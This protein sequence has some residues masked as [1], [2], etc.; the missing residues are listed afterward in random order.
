MNDCTLKVDPGNAGARMRT[1]IDELLSASGMDRTVVILS[2][3]IYNDNVEGN[4]CR[5][6]A[7]A[8]NG[9]INRQY[10]ALVYSM[11]AQGKKVLLADMDPLPPHAGRGWIKYPEDFADG[12]HPNDVGFKKMA[13]VFYAAIENAAAR[14]WLQAPHAI[15]IGGVAPPGCRKKAGDGID[16]GG[17]TQRGSGQEDGI[18]THKSQEMGIKLVMD[19]ND[20]DRNQWF[21]A[22]LFSR[23]RDDLLEWYTLADGVTV[24]YRV[25][26]NNGDGNFARIGDLNVADNCIPAGVNFIDVNGQLAIL[27][28]VHNLIH[29]LTLNFKPMVWMTSSVL[30]RREMRTPQL[31][32]ATATEIHPQ[33]SIILACGSHH[34]AII[35]IVSD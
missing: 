11:Q 20:F 21:F 5:D 6:N 24:R 2:T 32:N 16:A 19:N 31:I 7:G 30:P 1:L 3:L 34:K 25:W 17:Q 22:R 28:W 14:N 9:G 23:D 13:Y 26:K 35:R 4:Y 33:R 10:R 8:P 12:T 27:A 29:K 15:T 18:Y